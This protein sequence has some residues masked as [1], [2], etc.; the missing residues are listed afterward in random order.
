M[1]RTKR[2]DTLV[3]SIERQ[4][5]IRLNARRDMRIGNLLRERGFDSVTQLVKAARGQL[6]FHPHP[7]DIFSSFH[8][9]DLAQVNG[10]RLMT[11]NPNLRLDIQ[12]DASRE[13]VNSERSTYI[14]HALRLRIRAVDV[15]VCLIGNGTAWR[16]FVDW[17]IQTALEER[18]GVCGIRLKGSTG[19]APS[20]LREIGATVVSWGNV[21]HM[22]AAIEQAV[23]VRS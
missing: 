8:G 13:L 7:R 15:V 2:A 11:R 1:F 16:D 5:A 23:A 21:L 10:F 14:K 20:I 19:R 6:T 3:E 9:D 4:Y 17:E 18:R 22:T 12:A